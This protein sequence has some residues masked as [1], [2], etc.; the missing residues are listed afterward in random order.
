MWQASAENMHDQNASVRRFT[1]GRVYLTCLRLLNKAHWVDKQF[2]RQLVSDTW[3]EIWENCILGPTDFTCVKMYNHKMVKSSF[4]G[5][6]SDVLV[7]V[8]VLTFFESTFRKVAI[9]HL[10]V[11][12]NLQMGMISNLHFNKKISLICKIHVKAS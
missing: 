9:F 11:I 1:E 4:S 12:F 5:V 8:H 10:T 7:H 3:V 2:C 6:R